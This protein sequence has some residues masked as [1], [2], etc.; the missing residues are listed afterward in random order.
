MTPAT[1]KNGQRLGEPVV[2]LRMS[3][4]GMHEQVQ[5]TTPRRQSKIQIHTVIAATTGMAQASEQRDLQDEPWPRA[6]AFMST[7]SAT[8]MATRDERR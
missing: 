1:R 5:L 4:P 7:A 6:R 8:P 2:A 3:T